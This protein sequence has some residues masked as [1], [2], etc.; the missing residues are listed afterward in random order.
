MPKRIQMRRTAGWRRPEGAVYV[1]RPTAW[2][3]PWRVGGKAH[4]ALDYASARNEYERALTRGEL[5][6]RSGVPLL[7]RL[8]ELR[9]K[10]LACW[11]RPDQPCH[12]DVLLRYANAAPGGGAG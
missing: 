4:G 6:D 5:T 10:D 8:G 11:C 1:G 2:G 7:D 12:A 3:N 9:G